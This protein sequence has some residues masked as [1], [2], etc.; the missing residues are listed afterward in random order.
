[1]TVESTANVASALTNGATTDFPFDFYVPDQDYLVIELH[2]EV[3]DVLVHTYSAAEY[4]VAGIG[5]QEGGSIT[6]LGAAVEAGYRLYIIRTVPYLQQT[7]LNNQ[8]GFYPKSV[9]AQFDIEEMQIQQLAE[10]IGRAVLMPR[11]NPPVGYFP[12]ILSDGTWG[13]APTTGS[14][15]SFIAELATGSGAGLVGLGN[16]QIF[17][18]GTVGYNSILSVSLAQL[19]NVYCWNDR[20]VRLTDD[21]REDFFICRSGEPPADPLQ[22]IYV[23]SATAMFYW[24]RKWDGINGKPEWFGAVPG[25]P[26]CLAA[27]NA[28]FTL[29]PVTQL[30]ANDYHTTG[31]WTINAPYKMVLGSP[32]IADGFDTFHGT[33]IVSSDA[34]NS[35]VQIGP[36]AQPS[37]INL[38][39]RNLAVRDIAFVHSGTLVGNASHIDATKC[40]VA[41]FL[42]ECELT[43]LRAHEA[44]IGFF[45]YG[46]ISSHVTRCRTFRQA[47]FGANDF[48]VA[49]WVRGVPNILNGGNASLY[50]ER[51]G[52]EMG[53]ALAINK[54]GMY[55]DGDA[56]DLFVDTLETSACS[57]GVEYNGSG[58]SYIH[59]KEDIHFRNCVLDN[60]SE[61]AFKLSNLNAS[62]TL[63]LSGG[64]YQAVPT[65][66]THVI[67]LNGGAGSV[68][69]TGGL[70]I[71]GG[72][73]GDCRGVEVVNQPGFVIDESVQITDVGHGVVVLAGNGGYIAANIKNP[74]VGLGTQYAVYVDANVLRCVI[75]PRVTGK[76]GAYAQ[77]IYLNGATNNKCSIDP[78]RVD[79]AAIA[80]NKVVVNG[81]AITAPGYYTSAGVAGAAG[82]GIFVTG[83]TA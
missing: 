61:A 83:I 28:C 68:V 33:R 8:G 21:G 31:T 36:A 19:P 34:A 40:V 18:V 69:L 46:L 24:E 81:V 20:V 38:Y 60:N 13:F 15:S 5:A 73:D 17:N 14:E 77:G 52:V 66:A 30:S 78:T 56:A 10:Q 82:D 25:G 55:V 54:W 50:I 76:A 32:V 64:Y 23:D 43:R 49:C 47:S 3:T 41:T 80:G 16:T 27:L 53:G 2:D 79:P 45:F 72:A 6:I 67:S 71:I 44:L 48:F 4:T 26:D 9:E 70:Q 59:G 39:P 37:L 7:V 57:I 65:T 62:A 63:T 12:V 11:S 22:G 75:A 74:N 29:C 35:V 1:M 42:I 51:F 58:S